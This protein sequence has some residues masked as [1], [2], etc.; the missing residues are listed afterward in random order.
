MRRISHGSKDERV[1]D[2]SIH[3]YKNVAQRY[4]PEGYVDFT[5]PYTPDNVHKN[6]FSLQNYPLNTAHF[7]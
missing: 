3:G 4:A 2:I 7:A 1:D 5:N 6:T